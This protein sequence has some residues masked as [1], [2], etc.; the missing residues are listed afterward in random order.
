MTPNI[1][2]RQMKTAIGLL[3]MA[4]L[5]ILATLKKDDLDSNQLRHVATIIVLRDHT[6]QQLKSNPTRP[7]VIAL[8]AMWYEAAERCKFILPADQ[9]AIA[10]ALE[11]AL[12][13]VQWIKNLNL[14]AK[15]ME[16][17]T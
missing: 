4:V 12:A 17:Q 15:V 7:K 3:Q 16:V 5:P 6:G 10:D 8:C 1:P 13:E 14:K 2:F 11:A 9:P